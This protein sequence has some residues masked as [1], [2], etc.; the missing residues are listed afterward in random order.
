[1]IKIDLEKKSPFLLPKEFQHFLQI[2]IAAKHGTAMDALRS[3]IVK[4]IHKN[5][6]L[7]EDTTIV[8]NERHREIFQSVRDLIFSAKNIL[9]NQQSYELCASDLRLAL[10]TLGHI[11]GKYNT[12]EM[13]AKIFSQFCIGK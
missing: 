7:P 13:L 9:Q 11:T 6:L 1:V 8:I 4:S 10:E 3:A 12:E 2:S 5:M